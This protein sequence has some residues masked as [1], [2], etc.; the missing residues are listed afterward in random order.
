MMTTQQTQR[1]F[2]KPIALALGG[3]LLAAPFVAG[4]AF[5]ESRKSPHTYDVRTHRVHLVDSRP[6]VWFFRGPNP[7]VRSEVFAYD[8]L[9]A[10]MRA[11]AQKQGIVLPPDFYLLN[12]SF[13]FLERTDVAVERQF[14]A[15]NPDKG[16]F[17]H[18]P[19]VGLM[20]PAWLQYG[21]NGLARAFGVADAGDAAETAR[22]E[23][24]RALA[25]LDIAAVRALRALL[26][27][28][29][30]RP[31]VIYAHCEAG[32]DRTGEVIGAYRM[33]YEGLSAQEAFDRNTQEC[34]REENG[35]STRALQAYCR[36]LDQGDCQLQAVH[37]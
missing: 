18:Y 7:V 32:C 35:F 2:W 13:L 36:W 29:H 15:D 8:K 34:G 3:V 17:L 30:D 5:V 14:F 22:P 27:G 21:V 16:R 11:A 4:F 31:V 26:E 23:R 10:A 9:V 1:K 24:A 20:K 33:Q 25:H 19:V 12:V 28:A 6:D 37:S